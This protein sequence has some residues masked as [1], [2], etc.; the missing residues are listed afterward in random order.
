MAN[1]LS[2]LIGM[3]ATLSGIQNQRRELDL[4][5]KSI[6]EQASQFAQLGEESKFQTALKVIA[7]ASAKSRQGLGDLLSTL[8]PQHRAAAEAL[9]SGQPI[10]PSVLGAQDV[11]AGRDAMTPQQTAMVQNEAATRNATG[12]NAGQLGGSQLGAQLSVGA[13]PYVTPQMQQAMAERA[14]S[15]RTPAQAAVEA[16]Q[17]SG[18]MIPKIAAIQGGMAMT[19]GQQAQVGLGYGQLNATYAQLDQNER[20]MAADYGLDKMLKEAEAQH[21]L[22]GGKGAGLTGQAWVEALQKQ[23]NLLNDI[24]KNSSDR[25]GNMA[26]IRIYNATNEALGNPLPALPIEGDAAP[27]KT[28]LMTQI[29]RSTAG[30]SPTLDNLMPPPAAPAWPIGGR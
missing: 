6:Q 28:G 21:Y 27:G 11:Q 24:N 2:D 7:G 18:G 1:N 8:S 29:W 10:D 22:T 12:M 20:K 23:G 17:I 15:G 30:N 13:L 26:R 5:D 4:R 16:T 9:I 25:A 3:I 14:A 19:A